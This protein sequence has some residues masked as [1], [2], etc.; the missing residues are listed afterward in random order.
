MFQ[1]KELGELCGLLPG[2]EPTSEQLHLVVG[3]SAGMGD[4]PLSNNRTP[5]DQLKEAL[6]SN[7]AFKKHYLVIYLYHSVL[8][9]WALILRA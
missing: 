4:A 7:E 8:L 1:L 2:M 3:L 5:T 6:S 9:G